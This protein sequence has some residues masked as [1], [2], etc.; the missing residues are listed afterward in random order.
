M[1]SLKLSSLYNVCLKYFDIVIGSKIKKELRQI[2]TKRDYLGKAAKSL[3]K[4]K[5]IT[6][7]EFKK[8]FDKG[9]FEARSIFKRAKA[10]L[11][12]SDDI[13]FVRKEKVRNP[14][15]AFSI[16]LIFVLYRAGIIS[17]RKAKSHMNKIFKTREWKINLIIQTA[18]ELLS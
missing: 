18:K 2:S 8:R 1:I 10:D 13:K 15:V 7:L 4:D 12:V 9:E 14:R 16:I 5:K 11:L 3:L 17:K 6:T